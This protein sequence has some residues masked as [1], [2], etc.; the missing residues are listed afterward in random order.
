[1]YFFD[2]ISKEKSPG[3]DIVT[4]SI[5]ALRIFVGMI[6]R[7]SVVRCGV[8]KNSWDHSTRDLA[9]VTCPSVA[10]FV[11]TAMLVADTPVNE[12][13]RQIKKVKVR[14]YMFGAA[15]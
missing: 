8:L 13:S 12:Q 5:F 4:L 14:V 1:M 2:S 7:M 3:R 9:A 11:L 6:W 15:R 10:I